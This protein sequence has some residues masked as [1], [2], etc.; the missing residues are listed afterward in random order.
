MSKIYLQFLITTL[1][2]V[3]VEITI[4]KNIQFSQ[5]IVLE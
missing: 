2:E 3:F 1:L 5:H 4:F